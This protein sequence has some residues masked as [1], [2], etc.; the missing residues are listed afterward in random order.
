MGHSKGQKTMQEIKINGKKRKKKKG[1]VT[2]WWRETSETHQPNA[3]GGP[4]DLGPVSK[5]S[6]VKK[7]FMRQ[8]GKSE[9]QVLDDTKK[10]CSSFT[11]TKVLWCFLKKN[12]YLWEV[13]I[14]VCMA[15][16]TCLVFASITWDG[17]RG[18]TDEI[19]LAICWQQMKLF[20]GSLGFISS[21]SLYF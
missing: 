17:K 3:V 9:C 11:T 21:L 6:T 16:I 13:S 20:D 19:V 8:P 7:I 12:S 1:E 10:V 4:H 2:Y 5:K 18:S 15:K 14:Q